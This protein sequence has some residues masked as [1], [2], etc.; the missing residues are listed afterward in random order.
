VAVDGFELAY[1]RT[2][3]GPAVVLLLLL[4]GWPRYAGYR[5]GG[6]M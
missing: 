6:W 4:R 1:D 5:F 3:S 2:G